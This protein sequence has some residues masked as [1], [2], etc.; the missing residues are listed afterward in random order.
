MSDISSSSQ[1]PTDPHLN[2]PH[3]TDPA[4]SELNLT[5]PSLVALDAASASS[6]LIKSEIASESNASINHHL[7]PTSDAVNHTSDSKGPL[8][9]SSSK[10]IGT[11]VKKRAHTTLSEKV[12]I[13][14]FIKNNPSWDQATVAKH[15]QQL[16]FPTLSQSTISRYIKDEERYRNLALDPSKWNVKKQKQAQTPLLAHCLEFWYYQEIGKG[17]QLSFN[18]ESN[19]ELLRKKSKDFEL[20][21]ALRHKKKLPSPG[22]FESFMELPKRFRYPIDLS[23]NVPIDVATEKERLRQITDNYHLQDILTMD[24]VGLAYSCPPTDSISLYSQPRLTL[25]LT[26]SADGTWKDTP[27]IIGQTPKSV[28]YPPEQISA[29]CGFTYHWNN[30]AVMTCSIW[31]KYLIKLDENCRQRNRKVLLLVDVTHVHLLPDPPFPNVQVEFINTARIF[32]CDSSNPPCH[33]FVAGI[34]MYFK[35]EYRVRFCLRALSS[36]EFGLS[37]LYNLDQAAATR[38]IQDAWNCVTPLAISNTFRHTGI[39]S[40]RSDDD[41]SITEELVENIDEG[42]LVKDQ[43]IE[44]SLASLTMCLTQLTIK[45][46]NLCEQADSDLP[47]EKPPS[48]DVDMNINPVLTM[49][50]PQVIKPSK[51]NRFKSHKKSQEHLVSA[52][53]FIDIDISLP[54]ELQWDEQEIVDQVLRENREAVLTSAPAGSRSAGQTSL[55]EESKI[56]SSARSLKRNSSVLGNADDIMV[57]HNGEPTSV[58]RGQTR[59]RLSATASNNVFEQNFP[60]SAATTETSPHPYDEIS[61]YSQHISNIESLRAFCAELIEKSRSEE[62]MGGRLSSIV[63]EC[64]PILAELEDELKALEAADLLRHV[65]G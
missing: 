12:M 23:H 19:F 61:N 8:T 47:E 15:F 45:V 49:Q 2:D 40:W 1:I 30:K 32:G 28:A 55:T 25:V 21:L 3:L 4:L 59:P 42:I 22:C 64:L 51:S 62:E 5:D 9:K 46:I 65:S 56:N 54:T 31:E 39:V 27:L 43:A 11:H 63:Q 58:R 38:I 7:T 53:D 24:E 13:I 35:S 10:Q 18:L 20:L 26:C 50:S 6:Q 17:D 60:V 37:D 41:E 52:H 33:P 14:N 44:Q 34:A 29:D 48:T 57:L 36:D 16:G